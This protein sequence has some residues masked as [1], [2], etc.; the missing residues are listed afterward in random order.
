M[1]YK[2]IPVP[3]KDILCNQQSYSV[4]TDMKKRDWKFVRFI[5]SIIIFDLHIMVELFEVQTKLEPPI[6][7]DH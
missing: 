3:E 1:S 5:T 6:E 7:V 2:D 4:I